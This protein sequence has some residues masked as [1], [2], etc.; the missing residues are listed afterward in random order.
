MIYPWVFTFLLHVRLDSSNFVYMLHW[1]GWN[2][3][4]NVCKVFSSSKKTLTH[5]YVNLKLH[6]VQFIHWLAEVGVQGFT[7]GRQKGKGR[8]KFWRARMLKTETFS[9]LKAATLATF[10]GLIQL[11]PSTVKRFLTGCSCVNWLAPHTDCK[12]MLRHIPLRITKKSEDL[13]GS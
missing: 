5:T 1:K 10:R 11:S 8:Q 7:K 4:S 3:I 6:S 2:W 12:Q 9:P 13:K